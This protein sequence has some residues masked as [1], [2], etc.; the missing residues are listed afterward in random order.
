MKKNFTFLELYSLKI[1]NQISRENYWTLMKLFFSELSD[2]AIMQENFNN[3]IL[4]KEKQIII[5]FQMTK[6]HNKRI[7]MILE[8]S[9]IRSVPFSVLVAGFYEPFQSDLIMNLGN[10]SN[11]FL[12]IGANMGF[13]T[14]AML[15]E[16]KEIKIDSFEPQPKIFELMK[17]NINQ[18][19][20]MKEIGSRVKLHNFALSQKTGTLK[21][22]VPS[23]T[24]SGGASFE[25]LHSNTERVDEILVPVRTL[26]SVLSSKVDLIKID[27]EGSELNVLQGAS[28][29]IRESNPTVV[30]ELLRKWMK[31][32]G[33][34]P[35]M[36]LDLMCQNGYRAFAIKES[37]VFEIQEIDE[38]T[39]ETNFIFIHSRN[40]KHFSVIY[41][42]V[43]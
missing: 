18:N 4:I 37:T 1:K 11:H 19:N 6:T 20:M 36:F 27:V 26:D 24:G 12:D 28:R 35:Q 30:T 29:I 40:E 23:F 34:S 10:N 42:Y 22:F 17:E 39:V 9:D 32:F 5:D 25:N 13:Y 2:F 41:R 16:N 31:P 43:S 38:N 21:M 15:K 7:R 3:S 8:P 33:H 14:L